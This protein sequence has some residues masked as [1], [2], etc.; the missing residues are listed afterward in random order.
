[1]QYNRSGQHD[2][3]KDEWLSE[4]ENKRWARAAAWK[5]PGNNTV[6]RHQQAM[7]YSIA[8]MDQCDF[9]SIGRRMPKGTGVDA[10]INDGSKVQKHVVRKRSTGR[11]QKSNKENRPPKKAA[12]ASA[13]EVG[14]LR[15]SKLAALRMFLEFGSSAEKQRAKQELH[16]IAYG[17]LQQ[18]SDDNAE[19]VDA[20]EAS[21]TGSKDELDSSS[22]A[23]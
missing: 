10:S 3:D 14:S 2:D 18:P 22:S 16:V 9:E 19:E 21:H 7:I 13:I 12:I 1:M 8:L 17:R 20:E 6:I 15:E 23:M 11:N 4:K 5:T